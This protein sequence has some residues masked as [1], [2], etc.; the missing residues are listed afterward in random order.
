M[1][2]DIIGKII[3][4]L[5]APP[6]T[7]GLIVSIITIIVNYIS[8]KC[9]ENLKKRVFPISSDKSGKIS[10]INIIIGKDNTITNN[11]L[12][13]DYK[14]ALAIQ[15]RAGTLIAEQTDD[16]LAPQMQLTDE[17][18]RNIYPYNHAQLLE[19]CKENI[20]NFKQATKFNEIKKLISDDKK[21]VHLR[22][23]DSKNIHSTEQ[24]F[25]SKSAFERM[26]EEYEKDDDTSRLF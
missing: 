23:L 14:T 26:K 11:I 15:D 4:W 2:E 5:E 12:E 24:K 10:I 6:I 22:K 25:Y 18:F 16:P 7:V 20:N 1:S 13:A 8:K 21:C 9:L 17:N 3:I 19:W